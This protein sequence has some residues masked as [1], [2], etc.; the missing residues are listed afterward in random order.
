[1]HNTATDFAHRLELIFTAGLLDLFFIL[2]QVLPA[3]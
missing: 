3:T 2:P 1:M